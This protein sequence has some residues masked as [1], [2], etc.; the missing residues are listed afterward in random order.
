M[1]EK[2]RQG[3]KMIKLLHSKQVPLVPAQGNIPQV[4]GPVAPRLS[5][6]QVHLGT[7]PASFLGH[8][9]CQVCAACPASWESLAP[10]GDKPGPYSF[11][12]R[13]PCPFRKRAQ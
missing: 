5:E 4:R 8:A 7:S 6:S 9:S 3:Q 2:G 11:D 1:E 12:P 13:L 10:W